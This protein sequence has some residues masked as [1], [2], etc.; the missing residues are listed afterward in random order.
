MALK[1]QTDKPV[2]GSHI[3]LLCSVDASPA[4]SSVEWK[5][6]DIIITSSERREFSVD[7]QELTIR[8]LLKS[9][10]GNYQCYATNVYGYGV[11]KE[12][13]FMKVLCE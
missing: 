8:N 4:H 11:L 6:N 2:R 12:A 1:D 9:D 3:T 7:K 5:R 13:Y 10:D